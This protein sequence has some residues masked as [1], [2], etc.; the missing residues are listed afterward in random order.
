MAYD[1]EGASEVVTSGETG[2]LVPAGDVGA[3]AARIIEVLSSSDRGRSMGE[4]G[5][6]LVG[7]RF[8]ARRMVDALDRIYKE[9]T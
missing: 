5:R 3:L 7:D 8:D 6:A 4:K 9:L 1:V 2:F